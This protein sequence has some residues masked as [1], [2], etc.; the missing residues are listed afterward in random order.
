MLKVKLRVSPKNYDLYKEELEKRGIV[1]DEKSTLTLIEDESQLSIAAKKDDETYVI[2]T[3]KIIFIESFSHHVIIHCE[4]G[5][6]SKRETL[7]N[8][9]NTLQDNKFI[10]VNNSTIVNKDKIKHIKPIIGMKFD[11]TLENGNRAFVTRTYYYQF[12]ENIGF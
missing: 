11:L 9:E 7:I 2:S 8:L 3:D 5:K 12:K 1:V 6:Y 10:R 4:D